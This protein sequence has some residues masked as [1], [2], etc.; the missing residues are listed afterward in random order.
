MTSISL[1]DDITR[2]DDNWDRLVET[3]QWP[4]LFSTSAWIKSW[5]KEFSGAASPYILS[6]TDNGSLIGAVPLMKQGEVISFIGTSDLFDYHDFVITEENE[7]HC[8]QLFSSFLMEDKWSKLDFTSIRETSPTLNYIPDLFRS[9]GLKVQ[10]VEEDVVPG[11]VL[12]DTWN[13][14]LRLLRKK[15][16]HELRRKIRRLEA[17]TD[18]QL[19]S[20]NPK[21]LDNDVETMFELMRS[22]HIEKNDFLTKSRIA[23]FKTVIAEMS[24]LDRLRLQFLEIGGLPV[25]T[26]LG[27]DYGR[28]RWL[29]NSG[30]RARLDSLSTGLV[31]KAFFINE[32]IDLGLKYFDF[33]RGSETYKYHLGCKDSRLYQILVF[34]G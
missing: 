16:R 13:D 14:F 21:T 26:V 15:D 23:F 29:Y 30:Y 7:K 19:R 1:I 22:A 27:F 24:Q 11:I 20:A 33:L 10:V 12:P 2:L 6:L 31:L 25:A 18:Y 17:S 4:S 3:S 9:H 32:A 5:W 28:V 8:Y 34:R